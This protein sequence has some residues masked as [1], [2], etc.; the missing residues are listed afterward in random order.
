MN[1]QA[2]FTM[3][4]ISSLTSGLTVTTAGWERVNLFALPL[5][6]AVA[7][8]IVWFALRERARKAAGA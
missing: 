7:I 3:M 8:A 5:V 1:E 2:I 6:A 4:A